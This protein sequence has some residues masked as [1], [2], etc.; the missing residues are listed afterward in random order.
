MEKSQTCREA[1]TE[2]HGS[3]NQDSRVAYHKHFVCGIFS[4]YM[5][6]LPKSDWGYKGIIMKTL[7]TLWQYLLFPILLHAFLNH[8][9]KFK[10][11]IFA[12]FIATAPVSVQAATGDGCATAENVTIPTT[13]S[14]VQLSYY[15]SY[16]RWSGRYYYYQF[17]APANGTVHIYTTGANTNTD[18]RIYNSN[19]STE[20]IGDT[21][22]SNNVDMTYDITGGT[23]YKVEL[24]NY[25][26]R[27]Y[28]NFTLHIDFTPSS[29]GSDSTVYKQG[30][31]PFVLINP[32]S[33]RN[34]IGDYVMLG[35]T[36]ECIT[37][38]RGTSRESNSYSGTC[39][40][41]DA[42]ND[43]N[44]MAK[45]LDIDGNSGIGANTWNSSS[46]N[47]TLPASY[48]QRG[49]TGILWAGIFWQGSINNAVSYKQRRAYLDR[50]GNIAY[51][52]ITR[53]ESI[54]L[55]R[56]EGNKLLL[57]IDNDADYTPIEAAT[58]YYDKA[59][60]SYGGYYAAY[61]DITEI[62]QN[63]NLAPGKHTITV[64]NIT[65]NEGRQQGIGNYAGWTVVVIYKENDLLG[66]PRNVSIY[67]GYTVIP[68][69]RQVKISGFKLPSSGD[70][71]AKFASFAG[72]GEYIY[73]AGSSYYD[74]MVMKR[75]PG[76]SSDNMP[77][78]ADPSNIFDAHL[79]NIDRDPGNGNNVVNTNGIDVDVYDVS[80]IMER[81]RN[82]DDKIDTVYINL[83][84]NN[85]YVT[86]SMMAFSTEL[87]QPSLC[88][89]YTLESEGY[90]I[91]SSNNVVDTNI[92]QYT[93]KMTTRISL[94]SQ[95][96]DFDFHDVNLTYRIDDPSQ[97]TYVRGTTEVTPVNSYAYRSA[98]GETTQE[99]NSGFLIYLGHG[100]TG[101][102]GGT[103][104]PYEKR[105]IKFDNEFKADSIKTN[106]RLL[107][108]Y[109]VDYGSGPVPI[110]HQLTEKDICKNSGGY[111]IASDIFNVA[112]KDASDSTGK[113]YNLNTQV[114]KRPFSA[115]V[116]SH[117]IDHVNDDHRL[118]RANTAVEVEAFNADWF[119]RDVNL[120]CISPDSNITAPTFVDFRNSKME[121]L[122]GQTINYAVRNAGFRVWYLHKSDGTLVEHHC[123]NRASQSCWRSVY[124]DQL[125]SSETAERNCTA[126]CN[127]VSG[128]YE[129][130]KQYFGTPVCSKDNFAIRPEAFM[131]SLK[132]SQESNDTTISPI[133]NIQN[134]KQ[135]T[136]LSPVNLVAGY[137][138]R[139]DL[140]ATSYTDTAPVR[141]YYRTFDNASNGLGRSG[142]T[143]VNKAVIES[144]GKCN[145]IDDK[146]V[147]F[148]LYNG[149]TLNFFTNRSQLG[150]IDQVG[151]YKFD[152]N[153]TEWTAV[154]W[155][156]SEMAH[157]NQ[158]GFDNSVIDCAGIFDNS[159]PSEGK[160]GCMTSNELG[161]YQALLARFY[162]YR[163]NTS[164]T[165]STPM[166][167]GTTRGIVYF[168]TLDNSKNYPFGFKDTEDENMSY[169]IAGDFWAV[170]KRGTPM[171]NFVNGC[172]AQ[173]VN[174]ELKHRYVSAVPLSPEPQS[175]TYDLLDRNATGA[176]FPRE[177][178]TFTT[179][180]SPGAFTKVTVV[181]KGDKAFEKGMQ[182]RIS[183]DLGY[184]FARQFNQPRNPRHIEFSDFNITLASQP[185]PLY[186]DT[187][188]DY[189]VATNTKLSGSEGNVTFTYARASSSQAF[190]DNV[191]ANSIKTPIS[192][193]VYCDLGYAA[194]QTL[195]IDTVNGQTGDA[196]WWRS[197]SH[198]NVG[199]QDGNII[200]TTTHASATVSSPVLIPS[201]S[202]GV[203]STV[204]VS[205][206]GAAK[207]ATVNIDLGTNPTT[208]SYTDRWLIYNSTANSIPSPF[209]GVRFI[210]IG[211]WTGSGQ[212][213]NVVGDNI[214]KKRSKRLEW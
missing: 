110:A 131:L 49:G 184:N 122:I 16:R 89:D 58:F 173:D 109:T 78:A 141:G 152:M 212:T 154:D 31:Q 17:T 94:Q 70:I 11:L 136:A 50:N 21:A 191:T 80:S 102:H 68:D 6:I 138:Y 106:F 143:L 180:Y 79:A 194:C 88:Y 202:K 203:D 113:P 45:Y 3:C 166:K 156:Q 121:P 147:K 140:T 183:M 13:I 66:K 8:K 75:L 59:H 72:E 26:W 47:F 119:Q 44:Y 37:N 178:N 57:R 130:L 142:M 190:Y 12:G 28:G 187:R 99:T 129:C 107:V 81:Y 179:S 164:L 27:N 67:N 61:Q 175:F 165:I 189:E 32:P 208:G 169:N 77:G 132:D 42:Y 198:D 55:E 56:T 153:D 125:K 65:A 48:D 199:A 114:V 101:T 92:S 170:S 40:N 144:G 111:F 90:I 135:S 104:K 60:G 83:S 30:V 197:T 76:G 25:N 96:G 1:E 108:R 33:T 128:C 52:D 213:G 176:I 97:L 206:T 124:N 123:T 214:N 150:S 46:S 71:S 158:S 39:Q 157:H 163:F 41:S 193:E 155:N 69:S 146:D 117:D 20:L 64:A 29:G 85:D 34:I 186:V 2:S 200:L 210:G 38:K 105:F 10:H 93:D 192:V 201:G 87:Y 86:P 120:S 211:G 43:N 159:V 162:P 4:M 53:N 149:T 51:K 91:P 116:F 54:N 112:S 182:G 82:I 95:E 174:M 195:G 161:S 7:N 84:S 172:F 14:S 171:S 115:K 127:A 177:E 188:S 103:I 204:T 139:Y 196:F 151:L 9:R 62:L 205:Y 15:W 36:I 209:Y 148:T 35:N 19:C 22:G 98:T 137:L 168:N 118:S 181:Q 63:H 134:T 23:V 185:S 145:D 73:G 207:P 74:R 100:A 167:Q 160:P 126:R 5:R 18:G 24:Y 133:L